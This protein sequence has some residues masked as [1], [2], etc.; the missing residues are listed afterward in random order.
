MIDVARN[1][2]DLVV[3]FINDCFMYQIEWE[4]GQYIPI[5]KLITAFTFIVIVIYFLLD[6]LGIINK[7]GDD[8]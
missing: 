5:G 3:Q 2:I 7:K 4:S 8:E 1:I 6:A